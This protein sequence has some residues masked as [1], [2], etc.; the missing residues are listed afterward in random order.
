MKAADAREFRKLV[1]AAFNQGLVQYPSEPLEEVPISPT[2]V[3]K[4]PLT[5]RPKEDPEHP[6]TLAEHCRRIA[7]LGG[8]ARSERKTA[9]A[10][11]N[12]SKPRPNA[13]KAN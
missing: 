6:V 7:S 2:P 8:K 4:R 1:I 5:E 3:K 11:A 9:A 12:A 13:R 10:R